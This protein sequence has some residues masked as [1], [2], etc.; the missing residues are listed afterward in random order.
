[1]DGPARL[2]APLLFA[3]QQLFESAAA[4]GRVCT[5]RS[6]LLLEPGLKA[7]CACGFQRFT[8]NLLEP[9]ALLITLI[10]LEQAAAVQEELFG[11]GAVA[12]VVS[13]DVSL[14]F[15]RLKDWIG[16]RLH[17]S[18]VKTN[19][20]TIPKGEHISSFSAWP[21]LL[22]SSSNRIGLNN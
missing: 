5:P 9:T 3:L 4:C 2:V 11:D 18:P 10:G 21:T 7:G 8:L 12:E 15:Q 1:M 19:P 16:H 6:L 13:A 14:N 20:V 17:R 22:F